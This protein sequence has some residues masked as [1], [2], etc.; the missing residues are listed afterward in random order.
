M[1]FFIVR[2]LWSVKCLFGEETRR[3]IFFTDI[4]C[5]WAFEYFFCCNLPKTLSLRRNLKFL[6]CFF[7]PIYTLKMINSFN[8]H[9]CRFIIFK[10][11]IQISWFVWWRQSIFDLFMTDAWRKH[12]FT[13][14]FSLTWVRKSNHKPCTLLIDKLLSVQCTHNNATCYV[15]NIH[16][17]FHKIFRPAIKK[18]SRFAYVFTSC[19]FT[20]RIYITV[21]LFL[22][23]HNNSN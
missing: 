7:G 8:V 21:K 20:L 3:T 16:T 13:F 2:L 6:K 9:F 23:V 17:Y 5:G 10:P 15:N 14:L 11:L 22:C 18:P 1:F 19:L 4:P 12:A